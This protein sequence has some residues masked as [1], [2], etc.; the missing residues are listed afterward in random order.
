VLVFIVG[1]M[2]SGCGL[3]SWLPLEPGMYESASGPMTTGAIETLDVDRENQ[4]ATFRLVDGSRIVVSFSARDRADW[5]SGCPANIGSSTMEVLDIAEDTLVIAGLRFDDP[6]LVRDCPAEPEQIALRENGLVGG[7]GSACANTRM[8]E[9]FTSD[10][11]S[12]GVFWRS[13]RQKGSPCRR[14]I[15]QSFLRPEPPRNRRFPV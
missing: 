1:A 12:P 6:I 2:L 11:R 10:Q 4:L 5:P 3:D 14:Q 9:E 7:G 8:P 13:E 15:W